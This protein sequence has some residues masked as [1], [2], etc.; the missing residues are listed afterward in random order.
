MYIYMYTSEHASQTGP[1]M[2]LQKCGLGDAP[3]NENVE[4]EHRCEHAP[5][6]LRLLLPALLVLLLLLLLLLP[7]LLPLLLCC[8]CCCSCFFCHC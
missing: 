2:P 3:V 5:L 7:L 8:G 1:P 4:R 6:V